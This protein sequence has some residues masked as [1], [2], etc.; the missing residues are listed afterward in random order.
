MMTSFRFFFFSAFA[1]Y[2][3]RDWLPLVYTSAEPVALTI[4]LLLELILVA[5]WLYAWIQR[6]PKKARGWI[7]LGFVIFLFRCLYHL[8]PSF[9]NAWGLRM[10]WIHHPLYGIVF[11]GLGLVMLHPQAY[12]FIK[13]KMSH[14]QDRVRLYSSLAMVFGLLFAGVLF[15]ALS[16]VHITRDGMDWIER[17]TKPVWHLYMREPLTIGFYRLAYSI[18][19]PFFEVRNPMTLSYRIL[20]WFAIFSGVWGLY[21]L[22]RWVGEK[23][24][25]GWDRVLVMG[26]IVSTGGWMVLYFGHVEV[27]PT[28]LIGWLPLFYY[29]ERY[30]RGEEGII[31][32]TLWFCFSF[33]LH[34]STGWL[35]PAMLLIP[36]SAQRKN[37]IREIGWFI[38]LFAIFQLL[39]WGGLL[40]FYYNMDLFGMMSRLHETFHV[41]P[42]GAMFEQKSAWLNG[43]RLLELVNEVIYLSIPCVWLLPFLLVSIIY[44]RDKRHWFWL[45]MLFGYGLYFF[46]WNPDRGFPE[47]WDLFS[48]IAPIAVFTLLNVSY[49]PEKKHAILSQE[50]IYCT[51]LGA[52]PFA[53]AQILFH[54]WIP[55]SRTGVLG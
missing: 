17:S 51:V 14:L 21:W 38:S 27:Y 43:G 8:A 23:W 30:T 2:L 7:Y 3:I 19:E 32:P 55:F 36:F 35:M 47:D 28:L 41:G 37:P 40:I 20:P 53:I 33:V 45:T 52:L 1:L 25:N 26:F 12:D 6:Q 5:L 11:Y 50:W 18:A 46:L 9:P 49:P 4:S 44:T 54:H 42:D 29:C 22:C 24:N 39:F 34:L 31:T 15:Y 13:G 16:S 48:P 10:A